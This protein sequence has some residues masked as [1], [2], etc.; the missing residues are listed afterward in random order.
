MKGAKAT[1]LFRCAS[2]DQ[3]VG[4]RECK[5]HAYCWAHGRWVEAERKLKETPFL[6]KLPSGYLQQNPWPAIR[7]VGHCVAAG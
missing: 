1:P 3:R 2:F 5:G 4:S 7:F 6:I